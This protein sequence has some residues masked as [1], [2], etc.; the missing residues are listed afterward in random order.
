M[1]R[2]GPAHE[3][4]LDVIAYSDLCFCEYTDHGHC[5]TLHEHDDLWIVDNDATLELLAQ[6][7]VAIARATVLVAL[8]ALVLA[9]LALRLVRRLAG[10]ARGADVARTAAQ[11]PELTALTR[12]AWSRTR[13]R[14]GASSQRRSCAPMMRDS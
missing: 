6:A 1:A 9:P 13:G 7:A 10:R 5:G 8:W 12:L 2:R 3:R 4:G 11:L 14:A